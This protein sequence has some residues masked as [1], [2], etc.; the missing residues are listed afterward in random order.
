MEV[1]Q[2]KVSNSFGEQARNESIDY[3]IWGPT[4][5]FTPNEEE[6]DVSIESFDDRSL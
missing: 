4:T 5:Y 3:M 1:E 2:K 6:C